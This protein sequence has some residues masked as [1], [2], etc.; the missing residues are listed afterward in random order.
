MQDVPNHMRK[1][2]KPFYNPQIIIY[3]DNKLDLDS[4]LCVYSYFTTNNGD[5]IPLTA[6]NINDITGI[7]EYLQSIK[8]I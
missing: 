4:G 6:Q 1:F 3:S 8:L 2:N 7:S 5:G